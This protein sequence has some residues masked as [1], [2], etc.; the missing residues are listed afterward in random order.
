M[1]TSLEI[2]FLK[3]SMLLYVVPPDHFLKVILSFPELTLLCF[4]AMVRSYRP[5]MLCFLVT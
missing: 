1:D 4:S 2:R 3:Y 5:P